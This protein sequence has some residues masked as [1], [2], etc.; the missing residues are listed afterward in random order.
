M[1]QMKMVCILLSF[2]TISVPLDLSQE[3]CPAP[4]RQ[5][6]TGCY[7]FSGPT[8]KLH[9]WGAVDYCKRDGSHLAETHTEEEDNILRLETEKG[10]SHFASNITHTITY[11][12]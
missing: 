12:V 8:L 4:Y 9:W 5:L 7:F 3:D 2:L 10:W 11:Q 1:L 6:S